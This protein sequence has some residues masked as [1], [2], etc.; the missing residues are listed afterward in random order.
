MLKGV[1]MEPVTPVAE[2]PAEPSPEIIETPSEVSAGNTDSPAAAQSTPPAISPDLTLKPQPED[3][4][5]SFDRQ[6]ALSILARELDPPPGSASED[7]TVA[8]PAGDTSA[9]KPER[10]S[11]ARIITEDGII[12]I[13]D[14]TMVNGADTK[15]AASGDVTIDHTAG[16]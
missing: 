10:R 16:E 5:I 15:E 1:Y 3:A 7:K 6:E 2:K 14:D 12:S 13:R 4:E 8:A 11:G 9:D